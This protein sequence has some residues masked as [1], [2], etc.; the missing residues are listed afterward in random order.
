MHIAKCGKNQ[1]FDRR[2]LGRDVDHDGRLSHGEAALLAM[3]LDASRR[4]VSLDDC[5]EWFG[6]S[7][8][9][10]SEAYRV[11]LSCPA[12]VSGTECLFQ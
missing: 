5:K 8:A 3:L 10:R 1:I 11:G 4:S 6:S 7:E 12:T 9:H 2:P